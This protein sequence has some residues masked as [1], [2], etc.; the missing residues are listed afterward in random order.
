MHKLPPVVLAVAF[1]GA[2]CGGGGDDDDAPQAATPAKTTTT[3]AAPAYR[4]SLTAKPAYLRLGRATTL[5]AEVGGAR[6]D[7]P[8]ELWSYVP[9]RPDAARRVASAT[10]RDGRARF[11]VRPRRTVAYELRADHGRQ[12]ATPE[13]VGVSL[14]ARVRAVL[15]DDNRARFTLRITGPKSARPNPAAKA[16]LYIIAPGPG[17]ARM[18]SGQKVRRHAPGDLRTVWTAR[19]AHPHAHDRF[20]VC[21]REVYVNGY[22]LSDAQDTRCGMKTRTNGELRDLL[23]HA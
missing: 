8:V 14:P 19:I 2:G 21:S 4:L 17:R 11:R 15:D 18:L 23:A 12:H 6:G 9:G 7:V 16:Y 22:G 13:L 20:Y 3:T 10:A 1:A 5:R